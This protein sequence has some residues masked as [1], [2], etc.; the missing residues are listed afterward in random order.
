VKRLPWL[1]GIAL[2]VLSA[3]VSAPPTP[4][5]SLAPADA[6]GAA[7]Q[8]TPPEGMANLYIVQQGS[9][10]G[11]K[12]PIAIAMDGKS[13]G[14]LG[15][16]NYFLVAVAPGRHKIQLPDGGDFGWLQVDA[17]AGKNYYYTVSPG[18]S[19]KPKPILGIVLLES[20]GKVMVRQYHRAQTSQ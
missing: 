8:F 18:S 5:A 3:C 13:L 14:F 19:S 17:A 16:G 10:L 11:P 9:S 2:I 12:I 20:M 6:D 4:P 15:V 1:F 7:K